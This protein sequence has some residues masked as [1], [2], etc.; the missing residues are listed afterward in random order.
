MQST[1]LVFMALALSGQLRGQPSRATEPTME[2]CLV[3]LI[4]DVDVPSQEAGV[5]V[6][7]NAK[8][9][10]QVVM[11]EALGRID[12]S[13]ARSEMVVAEF[14]RDA[15]EAKAKSDIDVRYAKAATKVA[16]AEYLKAL[17]AV[18]KVP[19]SIAA[20]ELNRLQ[21]THRRAELQIEQAQLERVISDLTAKTRG[22]EVAAA[23]TNIQRRHIKAPIDGVVVSVNRR[24][25]EWLQPGEVVLRIVRIDLLRV[26][27]FLNAAEHDPDEILGRP[28]QV[29][30]PLAGGRVA[31]CT[32]T[33]TFVSPLVESGGEY[34]VWAEVPNKTD[35]GQENILRPGL[36]AQVRIK[37]QR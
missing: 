1:V 3:T 36:T 37:T 11:G 18:R 7:L 5:L 14:E 8:E 6:E 19:G 21:L 33:V 9:G 17:D 2:D 20:V 28:A 15:A 26:E 29:T 32:G 23:E 4:E 34:R 12:D 13:Q 30:V 35:D 27:G 31:K 25:G 16:E 10:Q 24:P 22:A